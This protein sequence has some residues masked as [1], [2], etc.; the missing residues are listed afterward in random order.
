MT[1]TESRAISN[2]HGDF[3]LADDAVLPIYSL[4]KTF[5]AHCVLVSGIDPDQ[6][7][8][9]WVGRDWLPRGD[10]ITV[11]HLLTHTSGLRD[12]G[13][14]P[15]YAAAVEAGAPPWSDEVF[16]AHTL[17]QSLLF[18][19]GEGWSY[20]NPGYWLLLQ[21]LERECNR[22]FDDIID[23]QV[24]RP[25]GLDSVRVAHG[26]FADDLPDYPA[27]WVWHGLLL[28]SA[29][30]VVRFLST[31]AAG[32]LAR[33]AIEVPGEHALWHRPHYGYGVMIEPGHCY[34]HNG[35]GPHYS[36]SGFHFPGSGITGCVLKRAD[37]ADSAMKDL[38]QLVRDLE[39]D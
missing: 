8:S 37:E 36:A 5:I 35:E 18:A 12:Y 28:A 24:S 13:A 3:V 6:P 4:T 34:G 22:S 30:D 1:A 11:H 26:P 10:D 15:E 19:P 2:A 20:S 14:L 33:Q 39:N 32:T 9:R 23:A 7:A 38:R 27:E 21:I 25:F 31:D 17:E 29:A 16:R